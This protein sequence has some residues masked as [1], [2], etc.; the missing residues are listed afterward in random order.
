MFDDMRDRY[1][2]HMAGR[3]GGDTLSRICLLIAIVLVLLSFACIGI[4]PF[5]YV[6][7]LVLGIATAIYAAIRMNSRDI[8]AR[9]A[10]NDRFLGLFQRFG[11]GAR[12]ARGR[13]GRG[14]GRRSSRGSSDRAERTTR[15]SRRG[16][17]NDAAAEDESDERF[18]RPQRRAANEA[19]E[20]REPQP[21]SSQSQ[22]AGSRVDAGQAQAQPVEKVTIACN[23]C[24]QKLRVPAGKGTLKVRC[25]KCSNVFTIAT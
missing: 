21:R 20:E 17:G 15:S 14:A 7:V 6:L 23:E 11:A 19:A 4:S 24:G 12:G 3:R 8:A 18:E 9:A 25:P 10:E 22:E 16:A 13:E 2:N 1:D 5:L